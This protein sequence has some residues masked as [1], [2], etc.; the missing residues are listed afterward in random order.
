[1]SLRGLPLL[2]SAV[3]V[4]L[5]VSACQSP[6]SREK[7]MP[8]KLEVLQAAV[9]FRQIAAGVHSA[10]AI[11]QCH[12]EE[13]LAFITNGAT[14]RKAPAIWSYFFCGAMVLGGHMESDRPIIA[15]YNPLL[16]GVLLT[17]WSRENGAPRM[18]AADLRIASEM[19]GTRPTDPGRAWWLSQIGRQRPLPVALHEQYAT[20]VKAFTQQ[21]PVESSRVV[22]LRTSDGAVK[23]RKDIESQAAAVYANLMALQNPR[24]PAFNADLPV[25]QQ[26]LRT[27]N[28]Q[29]L[30]KLMPA[31]N[32][33]KATTLAGQPDWVRQR[34]VPFYA[35]IGADH[36]VVLLAPVSAPRYYLVAKWTL[37]PVRRLEFLMPFDMDGARRAD[38]RKPIQANKEQS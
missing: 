17:Q 26:A 28:A 35:M 33:M 18:L 34:V 24:S 2:L 13:A 30:A 8:P 7:T 25:L 31:D 37:K 12:G 38:S 16:D 14:Y 11:G 6:P 4:L 20:F 19:A 22:E 23:V 15:F 32:P 10:Q 29:A 1:M 3:C 21:Y 5:A 36:A 27:G 9:N